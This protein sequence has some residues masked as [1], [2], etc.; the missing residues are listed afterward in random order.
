MEHIPV[1][2]EEILEG[3][4]IQPTDIVVDMTLGDG[5]HAESFCK[6][7]SSQGALIGIDQDTQ[8]LAYAKNRLSAFG[9]TIHIEEAN[10][11]A[12]DTVLQ[13][14]D[15][16]HID[17]ALYDL[18][19]R[20]GHIEDTQRGFTFK[21]NEPLLMTMKAD[22]TENDLTAYEIVNTWQEESIADILYGY[23]NERFS[24][25]IAKAIVEARKV[26]P[27]ETTFDLI[28]IIE[29]TVPKWYLRKKI[30]PATKT[31]QALRITVNNELGVLESS[32][33]KT[34]SY[35]TKGGR[36]AVISYHSL[37]DRIVKRLFKELQQREEASL[38]SKKPILPS[39]EEIHMNPKSRSAKLRILEKK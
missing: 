3:L 4:A 39:E 25:H 38:I 11:E 26:K 15:I 1:L 24:R 35:L 31:F 20:T 37:E 13:K 7:L 30:H 23:G 6:I 10:F 9:L 17:K 22:P 28:H 19:L 14:H 12:I 27:I 2:K 33:Q 18:G 5:G 8:A 34:F 29:T 32:L 16:S 21:R 36:I